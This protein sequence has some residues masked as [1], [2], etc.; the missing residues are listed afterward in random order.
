M[1]KILIAAVVPF[2]LPIGSQAI[3]GSLNC[4]ERIRA[5]QAQIDNAK[6]YGNTHQ[7][8]GKQAALAHIKASCTS[9]GQF[10]SIERKLADKRRSVRS[11]QDD[12]HQAEERLREAQSSADTNE[13]EKNRRKLVEKQDKLR[14]KTSDMR[15]VET[16]VETLKR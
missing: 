1:K 16:Y 2:I 3:A 4:A 10:S 15:E 5:I 13:I 8:I 14:D 7:V 11:A 12:V 6:R 9:T